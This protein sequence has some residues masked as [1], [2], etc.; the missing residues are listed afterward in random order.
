MKNQPAKVSDT[1]LQLALEAAL[2]D[3]CLG[4]ARQEALRRQVLELLAG[5]PAGL[6]SLLRYRG[7]QA[8]AADELRRW[9]A[10]AE[11][12]AGGLLGRA[13]FRRR[14]QQWPELP[15]KLAP[16]P[17][18]A[19]P[20]PPAGSPPRLMPSQARAWD[21]MS[22]VAELYFSGTL[23]TKA[24]QP[25]TA[26]LV[27]DPSGSGK[28]HLIRT[29]AQ[30]QGLGFLRLCLGDWQPQGSHKQI[31]TFEEIRLFLLN[32]ERALLHFD[33]LDKI[34]SA[35]NRSDWIACVLN[36]LYGVLDRTLFD[37]RQVPGAAE[38]VRQ[39]LHHSTLLV[40]SGTWHE[41]WS[42]PDGARPAIGFGTGGQ[43]SAM[44]DRIRAAR[45][46][47]PELLNRFCPELILL[48]PMGREDFAALIA[49]EG[50]GELARE[51][52][53]AIDLEAAVQSGLGM[54]WIES[55]V[56]KIHL[57]LRAKSSETPPPGENAR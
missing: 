19:P 14:L 47:P 21:V 22:R 41:L 16:E 9:M 2:D 26:L 23:R 27:A 3:D 24:I 25:R 44:P 37:T 17:L 6:C 13:L 55:L 34:R 38:E 50:L 40:G 5:T 10:G 18:A 45:C 32:H 20:G 1:D 54:R 36:D 43:G 42:V 52:G 28:S 56:L 51:A 46:I 33:E 4:L 35:A 12:M 48:P 39:R 8:F 11:S 30:E 57:A 53:V 29:F 49:A 15:P 31:D 7:P